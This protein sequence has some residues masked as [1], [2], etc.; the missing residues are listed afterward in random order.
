[1]TELEKNQALEIRKLQSKLNNTRFYLYF[2][3]DKENELQEFDD[4]L[5]CES[6]IEFMELEEYVII[7]GEI[8]EERK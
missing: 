3:Y 6:Y 1:M 5:S 4:L 2:R 7:E 8:Y